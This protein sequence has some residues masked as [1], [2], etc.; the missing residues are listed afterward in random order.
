MTRNWIVVVIVVWAT[1]WVVADALI[2]PGNGSPAL[3]MDQ[4][5]GT[6]L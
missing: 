5:A 4:P 6:F 1:I 3:P 2:G